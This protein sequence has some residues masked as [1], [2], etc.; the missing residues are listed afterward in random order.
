MW[1]QIETLYLFQI[2]NAD[3]YLH[4]NYLKQGF[5]SSV[6]TESIKICMPQAMK[7]LQFSQCLIERD[8][9]SRQV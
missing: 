2:V 5:Q 9:K 7:Y 1:I 3:N 6:D 8:F 4:L